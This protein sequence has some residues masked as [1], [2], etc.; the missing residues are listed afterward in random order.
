MAAHM[1]KIRRLGPSKV[2]EPPRRPGYGT[3]GQSSCLRTNYFRVNVAENAGQPL[4]LSIYEVAVES[5]YVPTKPGGAA[6][7]PGGAATKLGGAATGLGGAAAKPGGAATKPGGAATRPGGAAAKPGGTATKPDDAAVQPDIKNKKKR[8]RIFE[9]LKNDPKFAKIKPHV[10]TD[11]SQI[12]V[13]TRMLT[14]DECSFKV[15]YCDS[16]IPKLKWDSASPRDR[17]TFTF[18]H[19]G[20]Y[21]FSDLKSFVEGSDHGYNPERIIQ[22]MNIIFAKYPAAQSTMNALGT[23]KLGNKSFITEKHWIDGGRATN[24]LGSDLD[25]NLVALKGF[26]TSIRPCVGKVMCNINVCTT[27]FH[28]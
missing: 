19:A 18:T 1:E 16:G 7:K 5:G 10:A 21:K 25:R 6:T 24:R 8:R 3:I 14:A 27:A 11:Y 28:K 2:T 4:S 9:I 20:N 13:S 26:Y 23:T 22:A 12:L 17:I 15:V